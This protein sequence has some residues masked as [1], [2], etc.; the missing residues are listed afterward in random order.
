MIPSPGMIACTLRNKR[1]DKLDI[2]QFYE[3]CGY[4]INELSMDMSRFFTEPE[5]I[6]MHLHSFRVDYMDL[7][8][9]MEAPPCVET[10]IQEIHEL[11]NELA[12]AVHCHYNGFKKPRY[13]L[14]VPPS[15]VMVS[16]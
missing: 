10:L 12:Y 13:M 4:S 6:L 7:S 1:I 16:F 5:K 2:V 9:L 11:M 3:N 8:K 15:V 14:M